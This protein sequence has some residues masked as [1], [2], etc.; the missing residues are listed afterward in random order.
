MSSVI[1]A[2]ILLCFIAIAILFFVWIEK[3]KNQKQMN[4]FLT[5]FR[6]LGS[7]HNLSFSSQEILQHA[8]LGLDGV[9]RMLLILIGSSESTASNHLINLRKVKTCF[10]KKQYGTISA[11][12]KD[13]TLEQYLEKLSLCFEIKNGESPVEVVFYDHSSGDLYQIH[14]IEKKAKHWE[15]ILSKM[16]K[17]PL[18]EAA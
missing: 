17:S 8:A 15:A 5:R 6:E 13:D 4:Q 10:V 1:V 12:L 14:E 3:R 2:A 18:K 9:H 11:G 7:L 16:L